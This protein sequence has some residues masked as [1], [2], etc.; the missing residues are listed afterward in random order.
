[1]MWRH[2]RVTLKSSAVDNNNIH[3][4]VKLFILAVLSIAYFGCIIKV[5]LSLQYSL[6]EN[7]QCGLCVGFF[8][9]KQLKIN[10]L[11][12]EVGNVIVSL[13]RLKVEKSEVQWHWQGEQAGRFLAVRRKCRNCETALLDIPQTW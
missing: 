7:T 6:K 10:I 8:F 2:W 1:M 3:V 5:L 13:V 9:F 12:I 11:Y 4:Q